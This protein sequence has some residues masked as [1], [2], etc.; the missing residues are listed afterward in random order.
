MVD[1]VFPG[2]G[3]RH[4]CAGEDPTAGHCI[5]RLSLRP[6]LLLQAAMPFTLGNKRRADVH[7]AGTLEFFELVEA[8]GLFARPTE[9]LF[10][11]ARDASGFP[12]WNVMD[13][14]TRLDA[15]VSRRQSPRTAG[16][17]EF[18]GLDA[19]QATV[20]PSRTS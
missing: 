12:I 10:A 5:R 3:V 15:N 4:I 20:V 6:P 16:A 14:E 9:A 8:H 17:I 19:D 1:V 7:E 11:F 18:G 2:A 13:I